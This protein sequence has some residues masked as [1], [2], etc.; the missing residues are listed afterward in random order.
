MTS[1]V[2]EQ[3]EIPASSRQSRAM[4]AARERVADVLAGRKVWCAT[5]LPSCAGAVDELRACLDGAAPGMS[6]ERLEVHGGVQLTRLAAALDRML[7]GGSPARVFDSA[8][9][10]L[11]AEAVAGSDG[12][13]GDGVGPGDV[14]VAHDGVTAL[15]ARAVRERGAHVVWRVRTSR[16]SI[17]RARQAREFLPGFTVGV[18]AYVLR[19]LE[20]AGWGE[21]I[22]RV[23]A[24]MPSSDLVA[25]KQTSGSG[26]GEDLRDLAWRMA[27]AEIVR[28]DRQEHVGGMLHPRPA[29]AAR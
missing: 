20:R 29:V 22:E 13:L 15:L 17:R 7:A 10:A 23:A 16:G 4:T 14:V 25:V 21:V 6:A 1:F 11:F 24:A 19:W 3:I 27:Y 18:D 5:A 26:G 2:I 28:G 9:Q 12:L 8:D